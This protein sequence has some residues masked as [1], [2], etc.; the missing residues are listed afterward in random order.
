[1][2]ILNDFITTSVI[3]FP[4]IGNRYQLDQTKLFL[5]NRPA[6]LIG[7][8]VINTSNGTFSF[9]SAELKSFFRKILRKSRSKMEVTDKRVKIEMKL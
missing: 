7:S 2:I 1:M 9:N 4:F 5:R 8:M 3:L 6:L